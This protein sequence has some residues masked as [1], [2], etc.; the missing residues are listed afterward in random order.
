M[1]HKRVAAEVYW[2]I[3]SSSPSV[4][5][6]LTLYYRGDKSSQLWHDLWLSGQSTDLHLEEVYEHYGYAGVC[7][8]LDEDDKLEHW[9]SRIAAEIT[10]QITGDAMAR[11]ELQSGRAPGNAHIL[12]G[13]AVQAARDTTKAVFQQAGRVRAM[14]GMGK[15]AYVQD[16]SDDGA[17][18]AAQPKR[19]P[20]RRPKA[21]AQGA[22]ANN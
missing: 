2:N 20:R 9:L 10:Y 15:G 21:K 8:A 13:W 19:R 22:A 3:R 12:P 5:Q 4:R 17:D 18:G 1:T 7:R 14:K 11:L 6:Y 16:G